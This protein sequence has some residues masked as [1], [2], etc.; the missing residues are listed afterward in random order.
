VAGEPV[1]DVGSEATL[2]A[3]VCSPTDA[4]PSLGTTSAEPVLVVVEAAV[5]GFVA[6]VVGFS[7]TVVVAP[8]GRTVTLVRGVVAPVAR[9]LA[10]VDEVDRGVL[11]V[12]DGV[13]LVDGFD[14]VG[15]GAA[16]PGGGELG[17]APAP[18]AK[19]ITLPAGGS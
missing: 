3:P 18:K 6:D 2:A 1:E 16:P 4:V 13:G 10:G 12:D 7:G 17:A 19:P 8:F 15:F 11:D 14:V 5:F 9:G